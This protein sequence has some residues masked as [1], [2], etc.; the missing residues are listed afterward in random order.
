MAQK[1][2]R[3]L[4]F[5]TKTMPGDEVDVEPPSLAM[6]QRDRF[7]RPGWPMMACIEHYLAG[8][9][10]NWWAPNHAAVEGLLRSSGMRVTARPVLELYVCEPDTASGMA[11]W[12]AIE[13][14]VATR[15][16]PHYHS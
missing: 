13:L 7:L 3:S 10:T 1:N 12:N 15:S 8:D 14:R 16:S 6:E 2:E 4:V 9:P 11:N 5:N